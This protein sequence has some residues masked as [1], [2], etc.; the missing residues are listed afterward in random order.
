VKIFIPTAFNPTSDIP[1]NRIW[2]PR[3]IFSQPNTYE[4]RVFDRWGAEVFKSNSPE[5]GWDGT[6]S[7][8]PAPMGVY[9]YLIKY[10]SKEDYIKEERGSFTLLR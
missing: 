8:S 1:E 6:I 10:K 9:V 2:R 5:N 7:G 4:L 3:N